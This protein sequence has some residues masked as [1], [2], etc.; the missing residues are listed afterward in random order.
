MG[1]V[2][3]AGTTTMVAVPGTGWAGIG[4]G[5]GIG[6]EPLYPPTGLSGIGEETV[7]AQSVSGSYSS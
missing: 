6:A 3:G 2:A 4:I 7:H 5:L 1:I